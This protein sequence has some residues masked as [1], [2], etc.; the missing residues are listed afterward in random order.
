MSRLKGLLDRV[1]VSQDR[2]EM[3]EAA[4]LRWTTCRTA[5]EVYEI[6]GDLPVQVVL[7]LIRDPRM[8]AVY[9]ERMRNQAR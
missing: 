8:Q 3:L 9:W 6:L 5:I 7:D 2:K 4:V 1:P